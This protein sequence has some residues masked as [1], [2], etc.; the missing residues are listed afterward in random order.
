MHQLAPDDDALRALIGA[1]LASG[2]V[3]YRL[4]SILGVGGM[5]T[6]FRATR[7]APNGS[8]AVVVKLISPKIIRQFGDKGA[9]A[10][11]KEVEALRRLEERTPPTPFVVRLIDVGELR[12]RFG[13]DDLTLPWLAMELIDGGV[14]GTSLNDR[15]QRAVERTG[16]AFDPDRA[17]RALT[18]I[19]TG[20]AAI[21]DVGVIHRDLKPENVLCCGVDDDELFKIADFGIARPAGMD[22]T[23]GLA[24]LGTPGYAPPEQAGIDPQKIGPWSDVYALG[25]LTYFALTG[26]EYFAVGDP[27]AAMLAAFRPKRATLAEAPALHPELRERPSVLAALDRLIVDA[28]AS[29][30]EARP[31]SA[32]IFLGRL[33]GALRIVSRRAGSRRSLALPPVSAVDPFDRTQSFAPSWR[34]LHKPTTER[35]I[36]RVS[37]DG[38]GRCL[39]ATDRGL[40]FWNG[41]EWSDVDCG[42]LSGAA[43]LRFVERVGPGEWLIGGDEALLARFDAGGFRD[44][45]HGHDRTLSARLASGDPED[46]AVIVYEGGPRPVLSAGCGGRWLKPLP[47]EQAAVV[48]AL[49][50]LGDEEW[51]VVGRRAG[52]GGFAAVYQPL[53]WAVHPLELPEGAG[54]LLACAARARTR[55][56]L[57]AGLDGTVAWID[58]AGS[59]PCALPDR[60]AVGAADVDARGRAW[61]GGTARIWSGYDRTP[62]VRAFES[63]EIRAPFVSLHA[64]DTAVVGVTVD[65]AVVQGRL[66][67]G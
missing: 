33:V 15:V 23:F 18:C 28:T 52:G 51:I 43:G 67:P 44:V 20:L 61:L 63:T 3:L 21:H 25:A 37:W 59:R 12:V 38:D 57:L 34:V 17:E 60:V 9:L 8:A 27:T 56:C 53:Q 26:R 47:L 62:F 40:A 48:T 22:A 55:T 13:A 66:G 32:E 64:D 1:T 31:Q 49:A 14:E 58:E 11:R 6:A 54:T 29:K 39:A 36:R 41:T 2:L 10:M 50:R 46:L 16:A 19:A 35:L 5:S 42:G 45:T 4:D 65:G 30:P 24:V 7:S